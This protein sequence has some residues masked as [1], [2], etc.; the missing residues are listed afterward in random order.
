MGKRKGERVG[1]TSRDLGDISR[2]GQGAG[3]DRLP[4]K[5]NKMCLF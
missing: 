1:Q 3:K 4:R 5:G 2:S